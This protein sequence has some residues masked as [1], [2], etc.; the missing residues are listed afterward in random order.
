MKNKLMAAILC[1]TLII[2]SGCTRPEKAKEVLK[3]AGYSQIEITGWRPFM[4]SQSDSFSTGFR[5][6]SPNGTH[7]SGAVTGGWL[8]GYTIR[9]D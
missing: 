9:L 3:Q 4:Q 5:A 8:K 1:G 7:V 2:S 6:V